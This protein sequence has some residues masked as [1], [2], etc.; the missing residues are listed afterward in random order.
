MLGA[1]VQ[2]PGE[3]K[4]QTHPLGGTMKM[5]KAAIKV[6]RCIYCGTSLGLTNEHVLPYALAGNALILY[7]ASC[8]RC[9]EVI[10]RD[11]E[12]PL[13]GG[14]LKNF[15]TKHKFPTRRKQVS[16]TIETSDSQRTV[17]IPAAEFSAPVC[18]P[19]FDQAHIITKEPLRHNR[20]DFPA[21]ITG[22]GTLDAAAKKKYGWS[23]MHKN[24]M[25]PIVFARFVA[26]VCLGYAVWQ[27]GLECFRP[28]VRDVIL[29]RADGQCLQYVGSGE[30]KKALTAGASSVQFNLIVR[31]GDG[32]IFLIV[33]VDFFPATG[34]PVYHAVVGSVD[35]EQEGNLA[36]ALESRVDQKPVAIADF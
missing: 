4:A 30:A 14:T 7:Q 19:V 28:L 2:N 9:A 26:K 3:N 32:Q 11:I 10:N 25:D 8:L 22:D 20:R 12:G 27:V 15:R 36:T 21:F 18:W 23:G 13:L 5:T 1:V 35:Q 17:S 34:V 6:C 33:T 16:E 31:A 24:T 29:G